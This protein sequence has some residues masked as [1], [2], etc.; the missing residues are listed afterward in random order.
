[1][2]AIGHKDMFALITIYKFSVIFPGDM[3]VRLVRFD[4]FTIYNWLCDFVV[5]ALITVNR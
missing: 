5:I 3:F 1:M 4:G 2:G